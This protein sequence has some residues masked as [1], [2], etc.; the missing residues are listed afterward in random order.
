[1]EGNIIHYIYSPTSIVPYNFM[2]EESTIII[3]SQERYPS[4]IEIN[5]GLK[6]SKFKTA[7]KSL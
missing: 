1:M 7:T 4:Y 5:K 2:T 6:F 3:M